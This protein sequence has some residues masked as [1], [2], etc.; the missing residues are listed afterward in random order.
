[1]IEAS[2]RKM[3]EQQAGTYAARIARI[4]EDLPEGPQRSAPAFASF[5]FRVA[6]GEE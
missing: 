4:F 5:P 1:V 6:V 3:S 2:V